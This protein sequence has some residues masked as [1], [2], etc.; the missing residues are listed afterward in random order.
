MTVCSLGWG[1]LY[2][3]QLSHTSCPLRSVQGAFS[4]SVQEEYVQLS[5][6]ISPRIALQGT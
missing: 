4:Y 6:L 5:V 1:R 3:L 2:T